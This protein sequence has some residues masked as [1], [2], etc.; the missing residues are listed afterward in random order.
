[1]HE[2]STPN[3]VCRLGLPDHSIEFVFQMQALFLA[4]VEIFIGSIL[5]PGFDAMHLVIDLVVLIE[6]PGEM[7]IGHFQLMDG[8]TVFG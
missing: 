8:V 4:F 3:G 2:G 5:D 1:L 7:L 6:Q